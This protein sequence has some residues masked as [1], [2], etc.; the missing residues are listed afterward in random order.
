MNV[1]RTKGANGKG[2]RGMAGKKIHGNTRKVH[3]Y[4]HYNDPWDY[5]VAQCA[6]ALA[7]KLGDLSFIPG[8]Q[9]AG[10]NQLQNTCK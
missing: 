3:N 2:R 8:T 5:Q 9:M 6:N 1:Q 4:V 10:G 7:I